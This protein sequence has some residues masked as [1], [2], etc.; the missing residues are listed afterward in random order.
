VQLDVNG[1]IVQVPRDVDLD[2]GIVRVE[3]RRRKRRAG[4]PVT[5][6]LTV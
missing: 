6:A 4:F 1:R 5:V 2:V 3:L